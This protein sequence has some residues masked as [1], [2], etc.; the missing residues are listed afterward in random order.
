[1]TDADKLME[2]FDVKDD[3]SFSKK[4]VELT[5]VATVPGSSFYVTPDKGTH[6]VR[7]CFCKKEE[8]LRR[9]EENFERLK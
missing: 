7:F 4:L 5:K 3:F 8:T 2:R 1:M 6:Q 9:V